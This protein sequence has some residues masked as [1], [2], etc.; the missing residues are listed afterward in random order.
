MHAQAVAGISAP[1]TPI[2]R[3]PETCAA[4]PPAAIAE[5]LPLIANNLRMLHSISRHYSRPQHLAEYVRK[6]ANQLIRRSR[7][8]LLAGGKLWEQDRATLVAGL[9]AAERLHA[10]FVE[11]IG[12]LLRPAAA[13]CGA[14]TPT[15]RP[16]SSSGG[17]EGAAA[18]PPL[19]KYGLFAK[20]CAKLA[21][22]FTTVQQFA[23]L[24]Q[25]RH[26]EGMGEIVARFWQ[27][28]AGRR[29]GRGC[30]QPSARLGRSPPAAHPPL[31]A[32][33]Q[34][35]RRPTRRWWTT[36]SVARTTPLTLQ[37]LSLTATCW[38]LL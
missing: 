33:P 32:T 5:G 23:G 18:R 35:P 26:I 10:S 4:E 34:R 8:A 13:G 37:S 2:S 21:D 28:G 36:S 6:L 19:A 31:P 24:A 27:V 38:S 11:Q 15:G 7:Q 3:R 25:H 1:A 29:A 14:A 22:M 17:A 12:G 16:G 9:Q 20:R 30:P